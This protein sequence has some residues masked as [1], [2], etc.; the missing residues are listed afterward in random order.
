[1][2]DKLV[3][4]ATSKKLI[5]GVWRTGNLR[6]YQVFTNDEVGHAGFARYIADYTKTPIY[7]IVDA[8]EEDYRLESLPHTSGSARTAMLQRKLTQLFRNSQYRAALMVGRDTNQRKDDRFLMVSITNHEFFKPWLTSIANV[9][10][11]LVG[12]YL[13][14]MLSQAL[15]KRLKISHKN[16]LFTERLSSGL[17]QSYFADGYLRIS[18]LAPM[19]AESSEDIGAFYVNETERTRLY[20]IGQRILPRESKLSMVI[21]TY[22]DES[23]S[24]CREI[25]QASSLQCEGVTIHELIKGLHWPER[26]WQEHPE[27]LH[28]H[29][30][31]L[32]Q[33]P[34]N[35]APVEMAHDYQVHQIY[36]SLWYATFVVLA[37]GTGLSVFYEWKTHVY[38]KEAEIDRVATEMQV[39]QY[40]EIAKSFP[41]TNVT[42]ADL[43]RA[44]KLYKKF[45][46]Y[47]HAPLRDFMIVSNALNDYPDIQINRI[48]R[49]LTNDLNPLDV[50]QVTEAGI[51]PSVS[52]STSATVYTP[53]TSDLRTVLFI[54]AEM[55][56]FNGNYRAA[57]ERVSTL[58]E[59]LKKQKEVADVSVLQWP[60][61]VSSM[62]HL[63]GS[64]TD[65]RQESA[66]PA[67]FKL[68]VTLLPEAPTS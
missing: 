32:G 14:S 42:G 22:G 40:E 63:K 34:A 16:F 68:K 65:L 3:L 25:I 58:V 49:M 38:K 62:T 23:R 35:L 21:P 5:A 13:L 8:V 48:F 1:M 30:L 55:T 47:S 17:R 11:P 61:N 33:V 43:E 53:D 39:R 12:V 67:L 46:T 29:M 7:L 20:L 64:T 27:I 56:R 24:I 26:L 37:I 15:V 60:V 57:L 41:K 28:M 31:A 45:E 6:T 10:A 18:R 66:A 52:N 4:C 2:M 36:R 54:N 19:N 59:R 44:T 9:Q 51:D 50:E